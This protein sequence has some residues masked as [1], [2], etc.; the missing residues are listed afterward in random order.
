MPLVDFIWTRRALEK[1][2][3]HGVTRR[4][5]E[6]VVL[7]ARELFQSR[8][9][10][11]HVAIGYTQARRRLI[12]VFDWVEPDLVVAPDETALVIISF[13]PLRRSD[14]APGDYPVTV[15]VRPLDEPTQVLQAM[16]TLRLLP[17]GGF[18]MALE[19]TEL[20][21]DGLFRLH[22]HNQGS[23]P[24]ALS[25]SKR[26]RDE[27]LLLTLASESLVLQP[28]QRKLVEGKVRPAQ[29]RLVGSPRQHSFDLL[30]RSGDAAGFVMAT[31]AYLPEK[32]LLPTWA[33][34]AVGGSVLLAGLLVVAALLLL[35]ARPVNPQIISFSVHDVRLTQGELL[36]VDW[37]TRDADQIEHFD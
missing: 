6:D 20:D 32:P 25:I 7:R 18:G 5:A 17:F 35:L 21:V 31:R 1:I 37:Q 13:K 29:S 15:N 12:V 36:I 22:L 19:S 16:L 24:L 26:D 33:A 8:S 34:Y 4:E 23:A 28:G 9:S 10:D 30:V 14:S 27:T 3:A 11:R 2:D